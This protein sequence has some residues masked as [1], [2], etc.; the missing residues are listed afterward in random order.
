MK[1]YIMSGASYIHNDGVIP[2][3][4]VFQTLESAK[5]ALKDDFETSNRISEAE[6]HEDAAI[7]ANGKEW[8]SHG[9]QQS[10]CKIIE[11]ELE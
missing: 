5:A 7:S 9:E 1:L 10:R 6:I 3:A 2:Y 11:V 4:R 8:W